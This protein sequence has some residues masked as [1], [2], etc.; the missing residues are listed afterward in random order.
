MTQPGL[1]FNPRFGLTGGPPGG[2]GLQEEDDD[3][4]ATRPRLGIA[5]REVE[6]HVFPPLPGL[7]N[8]TRAGS[9]VSSQGCQSSVTEV[10]GGRPQAEQVGTLNLSRPIQVVEWTK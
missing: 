4:D 7:Q 2:L 5:G 6:K 10:A 8:M 3:L 9:G 1:G